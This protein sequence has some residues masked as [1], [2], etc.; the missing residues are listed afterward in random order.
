M[1]PL[2]IF[3]L[4]VLMIVTATVIGVFVF[5]GLLPGRIAAERQHPYRQ[6]I[7][8]GSWVALVAGGV[9]WLLILIWAYATPEESG[10]QE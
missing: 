9:L 2:D 5:L 4:I 6:A 8:V 3:A 10:V 1:S 7:T